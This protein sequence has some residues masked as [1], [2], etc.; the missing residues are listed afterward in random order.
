MSV[1]FVDSEGR[2]VSRKVHVEA[3]ADVFEQALAIAGAPQREAGL[4]TAFPADALAHRYVSAPDIAR[5][6]WLAAPGHAR[7][8]RTAVR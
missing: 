6:G 4:Y 3:H 2:L 1:Y 5:C 7:E 8:T